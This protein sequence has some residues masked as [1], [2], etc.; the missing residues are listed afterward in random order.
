[1]EN[2][3]IETLE[4][5]DSVGNINHESK[6]TKQGLQL[7][8]WFFTFNNYD[9]KDIIEIKTVLDVI[10]E[11]YIFE[12]EIGACGTPHLQGVIFL[13]KKMR[14]SEFKLSKKIC[15]LATKNEPLSIK[16]CQKE[17]HWD[18]N[19]IFTKNIKLIDRREFDIPYKVSWICYVENVIKE[20]ILDKRKIHWFWSTKGC[21]GKNT[22]L[23]YFHARYGTQFITG[24]TT[25]RNAMNLIFHTDMEKC[26]SVIFDIPRAEDIGRPF[27]CALEN[28]KNGTITNMKSFKCESK[29]YRCPHVFVLSNQ[30]P[31]LEWLSKDRWIIHHIDYMED[32]K[33]YDKKLD[34][35]YTYR[36]DHFRKRK[37]PK[38]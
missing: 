26:H 23:K 20:D 25:A 29:I 5:L 16:Y 32:V 9:E 31:M 15:W 19:E 30:S 36:K 35:V 6:K 27:Y 13:N 38:N 22:L 33:T 11:R 7:K 8:S 2:S 37:S 18:G 1:M 34:G 24:N 3:K 17:H 12:R 21:L 14:W 4:N 28:I 10:C